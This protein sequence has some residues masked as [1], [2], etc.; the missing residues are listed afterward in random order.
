[1]ELQKRKEMLD[2]LNVRLK[3]KKYIALLLA[4]F[5][6]G[7]NVFAWF[8]FSSSTDLQINA[9]VS[10]WDIKFSDGNTDLSKN[11]IIN[12]TNMRPGMEDFS[13]TYVINNKGEVPATF[14]FKIKSI[15]LLGT[16]VDL[17]NNND[18]VSYFNRIFPFEI[19][20]YKTKDVLNNNDSLDFR[21][22]LKWDFENLEKFYPQDTLYEY[23][24]TLNYY[25]KTGTD[26]YIIDDSIT[27]SYFFTTNKGNLFLDKDDADSYFGMKCKEY[28]K[29]TGSACLKINIILNAE[30]I[31]G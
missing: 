20:L 3:G 7:V 1:M 27:S 5:T 10:S 15:E 17:I 16:K 30:Q 26:T 28:E 11:V 4:L 2:S 8:V 31:N 22:D 29:T 6:F 13:K 23:N 14:N 24:P 9:S 12:I 21:F 25:K 19:N 18:S